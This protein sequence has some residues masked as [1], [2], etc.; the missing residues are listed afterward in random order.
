MSRPRFVAGLDWSPPFAHPTHAALPVPFPVRGRRALLVSDEDGAKLEP[1]PPSFLWLV[2]ITDETR[3]VPFA[4]FQVAGVDGAAQP[5]FTGCH[6]PCEEVR[7]TEIPVAWFAH[8][9]RVVDIADPHAPRE[10]AAFVPPAPEGAERPCSNDV[11]VDARGLLYLIDR[12]RGL[13]I[14]ER[15]GLDIVTDG[16]NRFDTDVGGRSWVSYVVQR[17]QGFSGYETSRGH[18]AWGGSVPGEIM[19]EVLE[20]RVLPRVTGQVGPGPLEYAQLWR[21]A[22]QMTGKPVKFGSISA[23]C[24]ESIVGNDY[25]PDRRE[26]VLD[27]C[28]VMH[29]E[30]A[31]LADAGC[32]VLQIEEPWVHRFE[33]HK[34]DSAMTMEFYV[35]AFNRSVR[36]LRRRLELWCHTCLG[37]P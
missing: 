13:H 36:G 2:D 28:D 12:A 27:L 37:N 19:Y 15:A 21:S 31:R 29:A 3:P 14:Q 10:V 5:P 18:A 9:L 34:E 7:G 25:Y 1:A 22:Q 20:A 23:D 26:L 17:L 33:H 16:D 11:C 8:G 4:S 6:Q 24:L 35:D 32:R 30:F